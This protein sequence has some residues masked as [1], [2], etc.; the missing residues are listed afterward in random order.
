MRKRKEKNIYKE[1]KLRGATSDMVFKRL[2][3]ENRNILKY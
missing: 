1:K 3:Q 2:L